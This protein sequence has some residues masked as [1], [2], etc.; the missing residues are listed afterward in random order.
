[1]AKSSIGEN[2]W[3]EEAYPRGYVMAEFSSMGRMLTA[4]HPL[5]GYH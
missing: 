5:I 4:P 1:M 3:A 2:T